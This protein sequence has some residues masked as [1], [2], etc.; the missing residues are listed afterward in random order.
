MM[1][2]VTILFSFF[3]TLAKG[4]EFS[5]EQMAGAA[6]ITATIFVH[7][8]E[9]TLKKKFPKLDITWLACSVNQICHRNDSNAAN[10]EECVDVESGEK[11]KHEETKPIGL[12]NG[13]SK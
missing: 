13:S 8:K 11:S 4:E 6:I 3:V 1:R 7:A 9:N 5:V 2:S 12:L 10:T